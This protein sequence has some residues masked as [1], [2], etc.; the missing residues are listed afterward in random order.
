MLEL[1]GFLSTAMEIYYHW[2]TAEEGSEEKRHFQGLSR[3]STLSR[4]CL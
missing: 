4:T 1:G 3:Q 2:H